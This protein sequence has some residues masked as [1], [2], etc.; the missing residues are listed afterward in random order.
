MIRD[1][2]GSNV[3]RISSQQ[4]ILA[5][6]FFAGFFG[7]LLVSWYGTR[8]S[9]ETSDNGLRDKV[10]MALKYLHDLQV[11]N[12]HAKSSRVFCWIMTQ[13]GNFERALSVKHTWLKRCDGYVFVS[14]EA[15]DSL[16]AV[17][18]CVG[19][20]RDI[21]WGKT[22][23]GFRYVY[24]FVD[25][26]DWF[27]KADD[28]TYVI[29]ENLKLLVANYAPKQPLYFGHH[30]KTIAPEGYMSGGAGY[31]LSQAALRNFVEEGL[32]GDVCTAEFSGSEDADMGNCLHLLN[33]TFGDSRDDTGHNR[34]F[35]FPPQ[36]HL[37]PH[38]LKEEWYPEYVKYPEREE[39]AIGENQTD[40]CSDLAIAFHYIDNMYFME[41]M[42]YHLRPH[43]LSKNE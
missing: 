9:E 41:Y 3:R 16:P 25:E 18:A 21:L 37:K 42:I 39:T 30:F 13:P 27:L 23:F 26:Y 43:G 40:C 4:L 14:S 15:N 8:L 11:P 10:E 36:E 35:P 20:G 38:H 5:F 34:F 1:N 33:V 17:D 7:L 29:M 2:I 19:E 32:N 31:L 6:A 12:R 28:D 24:D 22:K